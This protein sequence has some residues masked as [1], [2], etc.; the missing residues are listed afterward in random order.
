MKYYFLIF[1]VITYLH[2]LFIPVRC[3]DTVVLLA[4]LLQ[5]L[6]QTPSSPLVDWSRYTYG[7]R[8]RA[9]AYGATGSKK[10]VF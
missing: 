1:A 2:T 5:F 7:W 4:P 3:L 6:N 8:R 10:T 9:T